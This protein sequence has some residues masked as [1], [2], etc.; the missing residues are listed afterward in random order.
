MQRYQ[1]ITISVN[2]IADHVQEFAAMYAMDWN[3]AIQEIG[4][5]FQTSATQNTLMPNDVPLYRLTNEILTYAISMRSTTPDAIIGEIANVLCSR[6]EE[7]TPNVP[8][9]NP[10]VNEKPNIREIPCRHGKECHSEWC[11][12]IHPPGR[13]LA[14]DKD[15][16]NGKDCR[17]T[18]CRNKHPEVTELCPRQNCSG[19]GCRYVHPEGYEFSDPYDYRP[20]SCPDSDPDSDKEETWQEGSHW[21]EKDSRNEK[22]SWDGVDE[23]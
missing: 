19:L 2:S 20:D 14:R 7:N 5:F 13:V 9:M 18:R 12:C 15:C 11:L 23:W 17:I 6:N 4:N 16:V 1:P 21:Y 10:I 22:D 3:D 8:L